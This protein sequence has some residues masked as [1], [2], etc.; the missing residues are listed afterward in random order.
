MKAG[1]EKF[2]CSHPLMR[3]E[4]LPWDY[5]I[6]KEFKVWFYLFAN[7]NLQVWVIVVDVFVVVA[8]VVIILV[9]STGL[10]HGMVDQ[11]D[12]PDKALNNQL[13]LPR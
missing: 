5:L 8:V 4:P 9:V 11:P 10:S 6:L 7:E 1:E 12:G 3:S 13:A 2:V